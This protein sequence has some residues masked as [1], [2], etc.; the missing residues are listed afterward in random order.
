MFCLSSGVVRISKSR[1]QTKH[2]RENCVDITG[3][4]RISKSRG[5]TKHYRENCVDI[6]GVVRI[7][8]RKTNI[9]KTLQRKL[10]IEQQLQEPNKKLGVNSHALEGLAVPAPPVEP[11]VLFLLKIH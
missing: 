3:V 4:V 7:S 5:Q 11:V 6:T 2:Y 1:G 8:N 10:K 9:C